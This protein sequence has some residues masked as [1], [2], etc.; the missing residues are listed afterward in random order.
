MLYEDYVNYTLK[1]YP[2]NRTVN[3][4]LNTI[5]PS[6]KSFGVEKCILKHNFK[7]QQYELT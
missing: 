6:I 4:F 1:M 3:K 7:L 5:I 2:E